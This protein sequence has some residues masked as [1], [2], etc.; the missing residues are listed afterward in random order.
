MNT[1]MNTLTAIEYLCQQIAIALNDDWTCQLSED[2]W[3]A[4]LI[5]RSDGLNLFCRIENGKRLHIS[6]ESTEK[7]IDPNYNR[8]TITVDSNKPPGSIARDIQKRLLPDA[9]IWWAEAKAKLTQQIAE[10][11]ARQIFEAK[12]L[13]LPDAS[14]SQSSSRIYGPNW[15]C[16]EY[17]SLA[18]LTFRSLT[19]NQ[20]LTLLSA[21]Y[22]IKENPQ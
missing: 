16:E 5:R 10:Q 2:G 9:T 3:Y 21:Y 6:P 12:M 18:E 13:Q 7:G 4:N 17:A 8:P 14:K 11:D 20:T 22:E 1:P 19:H 15:T